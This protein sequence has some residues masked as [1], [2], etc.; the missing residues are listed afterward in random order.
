MIL[1]F[2]VAA[3]VTTLSSIVVAILSGITKDPHSPLPRKLQTTLYQRH[4]AH[5][6]VQCRWAKAVLDRLIL[7]LAD[8]QLATG[9][10]LLAAGAVK[11]RQAHEFVLDQHAP[12]LMGLS[13]LT[14]TS[15]LA[16]LANLKG[17]FEQHRRLAA[18]RVF[19]SSLYCVLHCI[20][21]SMVMMPL[22]RGDFPLPPGFS[23][24][25][26]PPPSNPPAAVPPAAKPPS[27]EP[28]GNVGN[29]PW[30]GS[31]SPPG[32]PGHDGNSASIWWILVMPIALVVY[33]YW[34]T[35]IQ[36]CDGRYSR[37]GK[38]VGDRM[39]PAVS[40]RLGIARFS[41]L[42][43]RWKPCRWIVTEV[44]GTVRFLLFGTPFIAFLVQ[45]AFGMA[46]LSFVL[47][48]R[49]VLGSLWGLD[50]ACNISSPEESAWGFG[51]ILPVM[52]LLLPILQTMEFISGKLT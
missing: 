8:Q 15:H 28:P 41:S 17:Y 18:L 49:F 35:I 40:R 47:H 23:F 10:A 29:G 7:A 39:W 33:S 43:R 38:I 12:F 21:I 45:V 2:V 30:A 11:V 25:G 13:G 27:M 44:K 51:Q 37:F 19:L 6:R 34:I 22:V 24:P 26:A 1:S 5:R 52:L 9:I 48:Q 32:A 4:G 14:A 46:A 42:V 50:A 3:V 16:A 31:F 20:G 36:F